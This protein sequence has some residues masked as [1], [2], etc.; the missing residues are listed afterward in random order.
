MTT[1]ASPSMMTQSSCRTNWLAGAG[2]HHGGNVHA[3]RHDGGVRGLAAHIGDEAG[4]H[5]LLELQHV[6]RGQV[7]RNQHQRHIHR[8]VQQQVLLRGPCGRP[9]WEGCTTG[10]CA[11]FMARSTRSTDLL[12]VGLALAQVGIFHLVE[13]AGHDL[14]LGGQRPFGVV[15]ALGNPVLDAADQLVIL[16]E[17]QVHVEQGCRVRWAP[18][19]GP[20]ELMLACR[21]AISSTTASRPCTDAG[22]LGLDLF[23]CR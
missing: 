15:Q 8:V 19:S 21:R 2:P 22:N 1:P 14:K 18:P 20:C 23:R 5:A 9:R 6:G 13:M 10:D 11:P 3:A 16:Q 4:K 12:H 7:M 17:H